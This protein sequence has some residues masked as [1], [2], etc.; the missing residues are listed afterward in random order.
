MDQPGK[1]KVLMADDEPEILNIMA[2]KVAQEG[3]EVV[4]A[5]DGAEAWSKIG[6]ENPDVILLD[7][8]MPK[9]D[10]FAVLQKLRKTPPAE[11][12]QPVI[13]VSAQDEYGS[14]HKGLDLEADH[15]ITKPCRMDEIIKGIRLMVALIPQRNRNNDR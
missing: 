12:W 11:K 15:Y 13:I 8:T 4:T 14:V 3:F 2:K 1:I 6:S 7:L 5:K 9:M 10:G